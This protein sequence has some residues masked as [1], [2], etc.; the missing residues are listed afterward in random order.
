MNTTQMPSPSRIDRDPDGRLISLTVDGGA[1]TPPGGMVMVRARS[2][3]DRAVLEVCDTG[4]G[5]PPDDLPRVWERYYRGARASA[6]DGGSGL[7]LALTKQ[8]TEAMGGRVAADSAPGEGSC[9]RV[10]L[11]LE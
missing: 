1:H 4:E 7:G 9:F 5:I 10:Y 8:L 3:P 11:P 6:D 2:E